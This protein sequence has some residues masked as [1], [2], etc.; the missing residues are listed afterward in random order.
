MTVGTVTVAVMTCAGA[1]LLGVL[2]AVIVVV[3]LPTAVTSAVAAPLDATV[4]TA[5]LL[6]TQLEIVPVKFE[7]V[8]VTVELG[9]M[10]EELG[11]TDIGV[12]VMLCSA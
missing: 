3:P 6:E 10:I 1:P 7:A 2:V 11:K 9:P 4:A 5:G 12:T 8:S